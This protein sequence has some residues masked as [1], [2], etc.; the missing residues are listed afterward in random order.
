LLSV[1]LTVTTILEEKEKESVRSDRDRELDP[2]VHFVAVL[3]DSTDSPF[4]GI[5]TLV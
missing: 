1:S 3:E 5:A 2:H 4:Y